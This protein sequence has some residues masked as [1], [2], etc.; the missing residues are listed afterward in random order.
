M[1]NKIIIKQ[2]M[3]KGRQPESNDIIML[4][5]IIPVL[6][7]FVLFYVWQYQI[8]TI[9]SLDDTGALWSWWCVKINLNLQR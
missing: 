8:R 1:N 6:F 3:F 7:C 9:K 5:V 2:H 4:P